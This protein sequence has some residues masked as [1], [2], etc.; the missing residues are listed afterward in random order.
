MKQFDCVLIGVP[1]SYAMPFLYILYKFFW[2]HVLVDVM[3]PKFVFE[4]PIQIK[5]VYNSTAQ[6]I[7]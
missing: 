2:E 3:V 6:I 5:C 1:A 7:Q 4:F